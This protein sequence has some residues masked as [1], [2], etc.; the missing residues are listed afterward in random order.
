HSKDRVSPNDYL[1]RMKRLRSKS[2]IEYE[3]NAMRHSFASYHLAH[4]KN[5][6]LT[7]VMLGHPNPALLYRSY[8][9]LVQP[10]A[11]AEY[12]NIVPASV[13]IEAEARARAKERADD[14]LAR[15]HAEAQSNV[16]Q[17]VKI[18]GRWIPVTDNGEIDD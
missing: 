5:A 2:G 11:A 1:Q 12:W 9:E 14:L 15:E 7:A 18:E 6:A 17:A 8:Y 10:D 4:L 13:A 3:Q 16:C